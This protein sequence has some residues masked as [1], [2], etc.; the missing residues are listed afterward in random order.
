MES[1]LKDWIRSAIELCMRE[2]RG[3]LPPARR[4]WPT[5]VQVRNIDEESQRRVIDAIIPAWRSLEAVRFPAELLP[6]E[7]RTSVER[8]DLLIANVNIGA[9]R[10]EDLFLREFRRAPDPL[11]EAQIGSSGGT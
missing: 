2:V 8:D 7:L 10:Q 1:A 5:L 11:P 6:A 9:E 3:D 4:P